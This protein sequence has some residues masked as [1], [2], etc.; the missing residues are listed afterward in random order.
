MAL[1]IG[2]NALYLI[3]GGVGGTEIYLR[4]LLEA[5]QETDRINHYFVFV[6]RETD[7]ELV[8]RGERFHLV[9]CT[10]AARIRP[11]RITYEQTVLA[12]LL[13]KYGISVLLN[14]GYTS[15]ALSPCPVVSVFHDLQH[16]VHP[17]F[18]RPAQLPFWNLLLWASARTSKRIIAVS[19]NTAADL[20]KYMPF[21]DTKTSVVPHGVDPAF[22]EIATRRSLKCDRNESAG[23]RCEADRLLLTVSTLHPHKNVARLIQAFAS[24]RVNRPEYR[25]VVA[26]LRGFATAQI[27]QLVR[28]LNLDGC[29]ELTGWIPQADLYSLF[30]RA[31]AFVAPSLF[32]G[33]GLTLA[34]ALAAGLPTACSDIPVF[35][36]VAGTSTVRFN[37]QCVT[38]MTEAMHK[39]TGDEAFRSFARTAGPA[40]VQSLRW[41]RTAVLTL[42]E[43]VKAATPC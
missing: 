40:Q 33:F 18:F 13:K 23:I 37:P 2:V 9:R 7:P 32:E 30:E 4:R 8:P 1:R 34:E 38:A 26:G 16:K 42:E 39:V 31:D 11:L 22:S 35:D 27:E 10:V 3:P 15:P 28:T 20:A 19:S 5:M 25:L 17:A 12:A 29:V 43:L 36:S 21:A 6:N 14:P 41:T 24:F